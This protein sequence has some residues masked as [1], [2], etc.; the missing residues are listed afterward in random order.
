M[1]YLQRWQRFWAGIDFTCRHLKDI[2]PRC[3]SPVCLLKPPP[4]RPCSHPTFT[5]YTSLYLHFSSVCVLL[6]LATHQHKGSLLTWPTTVHLAITTKVHVSPP[7]DAPSLFPPQLSTSFSSSFTYLFIMFIIIIFFLTI[8]GCC[9][10]D[11]NVSGGIMQIRIEFKMI[12]KK[13]QIAWKLVV[14]KN[15]HT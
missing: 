8:S 12:A 15:T 1:G 9:P 11:R 14:C 3:N 6:S 4:W 13:K 2:R 10:S 5:V 7:S